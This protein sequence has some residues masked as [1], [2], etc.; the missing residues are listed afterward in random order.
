MYCTKCGT[1]NPDDAQLCRSCSWVLTST[2]TQAPGP[3]TKTSGLAITALVLAILSPLTCFVTA[4]PAVI[5]GIISLV[6]IERS[7]GKL[8]GK[9]LAITGIVVP[10]VLLP[11]LMMIGILMPALARVRK[12]AKAVLC[13]S[14]LKQ[15]GVVFSMYVHDNDGYFFEDVNWLDS[16]R[17]YYRDENLL[18]CP[19]AT[20]SQDEG[21]RVPFAAWC[22][23]DFKGSYGMNYWL[24]NAPRGQTIETRKPEYLWK[25]ANVKGAAY[26]PLFLDCSS[27]GVWPLHSDKPPEYYGQPKGE[28]TNG[29]EIRDCCINRHNGFVNGIFLDYSVKKI[30][31]KEL[32]KLKWHRAFD[33]NGGPTKNEWPEWMKKFEDHSK[34]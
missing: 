28:G 11:I 31:L 8:T 12:Q 6:K 16:L 7:G 17:P 19:M 10:V 1:E 29:N 23:R 22:D 26:I 33:L 24:I 25:T 9:G 3:D 27:P 15:W 21:G 5:L 2:S 13:Q 4:I 18:L 14:N 20:K 34:Y 30:G 32:W